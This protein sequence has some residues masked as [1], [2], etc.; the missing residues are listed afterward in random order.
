M[1]GLTTMEIG[2]LTSA[3]IPALDVNNLTAA[4]AGGFSSAPFTGAQISFM[5]PG[6]KTALGF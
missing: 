3:Q 6:E 4:V 1:V 2:A 5:T